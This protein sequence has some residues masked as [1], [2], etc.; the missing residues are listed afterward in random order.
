VVVEKIVPAIVVVEDGVTAAVVK[1]V[2]VD[3][4]ETVLVIVEVGE[5]EVSAR[6]IG[7]VIVNEAVRT[8]V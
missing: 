4:K 5:I 1:A 2:E 3:D 7:V 6:E 8:D